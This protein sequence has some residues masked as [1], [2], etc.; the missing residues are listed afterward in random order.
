MGAR[1]ARHAPV[2]LSLGLGGAE[3]VD[4][5]DT[6]EGVVTKLEQQYLAHRAAMAR[7]YME[8]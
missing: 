6:T 2:D 8:A 7:R 5:I 3:L 1:G 4:D